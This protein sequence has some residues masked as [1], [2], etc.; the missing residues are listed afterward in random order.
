MNRYIIA[1]AIHN[2]DTLQ[3]WAVHNVDFSSSVL[4]SCYDLVFVV[5]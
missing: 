4:F 1:D 5:L 2:R 3:R